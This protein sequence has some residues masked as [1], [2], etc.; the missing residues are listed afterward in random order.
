MKILK[1]I[2]KVLL[3]FLLVLLL[4]GAAVMAMRA[5]NTSRYKPEDYDR[6]DNVYADPT[7]LTRY[8]APEGAA[9]EHITGAYLNGFHLKPTRKLHEGIVVTF[10]GSEGSP[11]YE[12]ASALAKEGYEVLALFFFGMDNQQE[13]LDQVPL[14]FFDE[15]LA[16]IREN[17]E[18]GEVLTVYGASK[19]AELGLNLAVR[20]PEIDNLILM[21][22]A[23]YSYMGLS[24]TS[25]QLHSSWTWKGEEVP[26]I[27]MTKGK[28]SSMLGQMVAMATKSPL[29]YRAG[30]ESSAEND[31]EREQARIKVE[32]T[33]ANLLLLAGSEDAMWQS[34][35]AARRIGEKRPQNTDVH[36]YDGAGHLFDGDGI[37][38]ADFAV[39]A[40][41]G[42][43]E[44]NE[45]AFDASD[46]V[47]KEKLA[48]W[49]PSVQE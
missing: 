9:A 41:G 7:D 16:Y 45:K 1:R 27:D 44:A 38:Y 34:E 40:M 32:D 24:F 19:G 13:E 47:I 28:M 25:R 8:P 36:I 37:A 15:V 20:Y 42:T 11:G 10:G 5:Y 33:R 4:L 18:D 31:P 39:L 26:F 48:E 23:E 35:V 30:Y 49:H 17:V 12:M 22:L 3:G 43:R 2:G 46:T 6:P 29:S 21:A 14:D